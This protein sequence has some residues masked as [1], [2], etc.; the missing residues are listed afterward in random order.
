MLIPGGFGDRGIQGKIMSAKYARENNIPYLGLGLGMQVA[1]I[2][3]ARNVMNLADANSTEF[4]A[5]TK[6]PVITL[7]EDIEKGTSM[8]L[9]SYECQ[10]EKDSLSAKA[11]GEEFIKERH[12]NRYEF[13]NLYRDKLAEAGMKIT[14]VNPKRDLVEAVELKDHSW[15]VGVSFHPEFQSKPTKPHPLF[16]AFVAKALEYANSK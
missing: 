10:L 12:R 15:F 4:D 8:R 3:Y 6:N 16:C 2:E 7:V 1:I 9:G 13:N 14:G 5:D 11:Y